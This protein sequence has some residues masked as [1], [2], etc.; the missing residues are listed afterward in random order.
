MPA[1]QY[2]PGSIVAVWRG[3]RLRG[4]ADGT[5]LNAERTEDGWSLSVGADGATTR[6]RN[7]N[8]SGTVTFTLQAESAAND[9]LSTAALQDELF[10]T[11][12][13]ELMVKDLLGNTLVE[14]PT[15]WIRKIAPVGMAKDA[16]TREWAIDCADLA[17]FVG[18]SVTL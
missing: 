7:R 16:G 9:E 4:F 2:D 14:S 6:V 13:G 11:A 8:R 18:G 10:G 1:N 12:V 15:A 5:F 17:P 3:I